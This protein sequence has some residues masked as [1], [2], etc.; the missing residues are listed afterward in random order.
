MN[1]T[2]EQSTDQLR[3]PYAFLPQIGTIEYNCI[4]SQWLS[5]TDLSHFV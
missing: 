5:Y 1:N 2:G 3:M 4:I